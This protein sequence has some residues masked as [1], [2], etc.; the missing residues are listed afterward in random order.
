MLASIEMSS[1]QLVLTHVEETESAWRG[2]NAAPSR[3]FLCLA[4]LSVPVRL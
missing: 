2:V 1:N 4:A 3:D